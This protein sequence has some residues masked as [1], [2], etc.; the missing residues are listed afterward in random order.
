[1]RKTAVFKSACFNKG[2]LMVA[3]HAI[4]RGAEATLDSGRLK[5]CRT[6]CD[7]K[8]VAEGIG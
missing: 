6:F 2:N 5:A 7:L 4:L 1:M 3:F 8:A